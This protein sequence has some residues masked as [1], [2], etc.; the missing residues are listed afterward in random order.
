MR[1]PGSTTRHLD[2]TEAAIIKTINR[3]YGLSIYCADFM[4]QPLQDAVIL[5]RI[6]RY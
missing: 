3:D 6:F 5:I 4:L 1:L 2:V